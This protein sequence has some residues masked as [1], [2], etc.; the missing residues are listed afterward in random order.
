MIERMCL[1]CPTMIK[2]V[3]SKHLRCDAC[4]KKRLKV[5]VAAWKARKLE[6]RIAAGRA[7]RAGTA[8]PAPKRGECQHPG[9]GVEVVGRFKMCSTHRLENTR[10]Q[11]RESWKRRYALQAQAD[12]DKIMHDSKKAAAIAK[13][14]AERQ[15]LAAGILNSP[16]ATPTPVAVA[17][18]AATGAAPVA[19]AALTM[20]GAGGGTPPAGGRGAEP[21]DL[22]WDATACVTPA[23]P[24]R[25]ALQAVESEARRLDGRLQDL[26]AASRV[27]RSLLPMAEVQ[28]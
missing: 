19:D 3:N 20:P 15:A 21:R 5:T 1:D 10:R 18:A 27:L 28:P 16:T 7:A 14:T 8:P 26:N 17:T 13:M 9:C 24:L 23:N 6:E 12:A 25:L 22:E 2:P 11:K 4:R